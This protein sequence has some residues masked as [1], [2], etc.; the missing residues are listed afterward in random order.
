MKEQF[1]SIKMGKELRIMRELK[2]NKI[3]KVL[4]NRIEK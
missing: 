2:K 4:I 3:I 1:D